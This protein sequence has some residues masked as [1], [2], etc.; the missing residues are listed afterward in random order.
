M[1]RYGT[2]S[3]VFVCA[4]T[5]AAISFMAPWRAAQAQDAPRVEI[6]EGVVEPLPIAIVDFTA[7][8]GQPSDLGTRISE[9]ITADL[10]SSGLFR[11]IARAAF[12]QTDLSFADIPRFPDWR[13]ISADALVVGR[14]SQP[15]DGQL[16][17]EFRLWNVPGEEQSAGLSFVTAENNWRRIS[18]IT[19]DAIYERLTGEGGYFDSRVVFVDEKGPKNA[20]IK[21]LAIMDY[22]GENVRYL[23]SGK[24]LVLTPR[25]SSTTQDITYL[26]YRNGRPLVYLFNI[27]TGREELLG[28]FPG[29]SFAPAFSP[30]GES[31][32]MSLAKGGNSDIYAMSLATRSA[33]RLTDHPAIDTSPSYSPDGTRIVFNSDRG[34]S[35]QLYVMD[36]SGAGV[37]RISFGDGRYATPVWSPR[38]DLIA[39]TKISGGR[40]SIGVMRP[41]GT[42]ERIL[43]ES[44][45]DEG[46]TWSPNGRV[47][48]FFR[49]SPGTAGR[50]RLY[51]I[52]L[53]GTNLR[54]VS[55]PRDASDPA[56]SPL[57]SR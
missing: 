31:V 13:I 25:Y 20:R 12:I 51:S 38:G 1:R 9:V 28:K 4:L 16:K 32:V 57:L 52:D 15:G 19:A 46:P 39:F 11:P 27:T 22:D 5:L 26:S 50:T 41:D 33:R 35:Q 43:T 42:D 7:L 49:Q 18:H 2:T 3:W 44:F 30:G 40:F 47:L 34:G 53:T 48:M 14:V 17:V 45:L 56:W 55:T 8:D 24:S 6:T 21:R 23:T 10:E 36:A 29:M 54:V 37:A